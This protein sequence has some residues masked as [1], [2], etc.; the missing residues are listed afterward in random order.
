MCMHSLLFLAKLCPSLPTILKLSSVVWWPMVDWWP[1]MGEG[2]F[3]CSLNL[4]QKCSSRFSYVF[5][6]A[7]Q[8]VAPIPV[9]Y[10]TFLYFVLILWCCQL[11]ILENYL[12]LKYVWIPYL[13][14]IFLMHSHRSC[15]YNI[16]VY[17][18]KLL[19]LGLFCMKF[20]CSI[21]SKAHA[22]YLHYVLVWNQLP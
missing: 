18:L 16:T 6:I 15:I 2:A 7:V 4:S 10:T 8:P 20:V 3:R 5:F 13:P 17:P 12:S 9:Y 19:L 21:L 1:Y 22:G 11:I 14:H